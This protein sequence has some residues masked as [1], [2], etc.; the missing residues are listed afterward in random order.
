MKNFNIPTKNKNYW[1]NKLA[2]IAFA[3]LLTIS[4]FLTYRIYKIEYSKEVLQV[5]EKTSDVRNQLESMINNSL[6]VV[7][8]ITFITE[9]N[10]DETEFEK[11]SKSLLEK[12]EYINA[13]QL[14]KNYTIYKTY[15]LEGNE[16]TIGF[17]INADS[18]KKNR[19]FE[20]IKKEKIFFEGPIKL[21]QGGEGVVGRQP[22]FKDNKFWGFSAI[23]IKTDN[24]LKKIKLNNSGSGELFEYQIVQKHTDLRGAKFFKNSTNFNE[25]IVNK[26]YLPS[27]DWYLY[28]KLKNPQ[29]INKA[30]E[31]FISSIFLSLIIAIYLRKLSQD[32]IKLEELIK[33]KTQDLENLNHQLELRA[34]ELSEVNKEL[35]HFAYV[36][37]HDLQEPLR[38][39][40]GFLTKIEKKYND[41]LDDKGKQYI[42]FAVDGAK[43]MKK[44]IL[45]ILEFS[46]AGKYTEE[47]ELIDLNEVVEEIKGFY[48]NSYPNGLLTYEKLPVIR[49]YKSPVFQ[50]FQNLIGN[51]FKYSKPN[52]IPFIRVKVIEITNDNV[53]I[54]ITDNGIGIEQE[55]LDKIFVIFQRLE[56]DIHIKGTGIGLAIVKKIVERLGGTI[57]VKSVKNVGSTFYFT[58]PIK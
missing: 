41:V 35:E 36:I 19:L 40:T 46:K 45:D 34:K 52:E 28:V 5:K 49:S 14:V 22:I 33:K 39:I 48:T 53:T 3:V 51:A 57:W 21:H 37:S 17:N 12:N 31:F 11:I 13:T 47:K 27:G 1:P 54:A 15:P 24:F 23:I 10:F 25:G 29:Y 6:N 7:K 9:N 58:L 55:Y 2:L 18:L 32:P 44:I 8:I 38:M 26:T 4:S 42:F 50:V 20:A 30:L 56:N 43:R 16:K